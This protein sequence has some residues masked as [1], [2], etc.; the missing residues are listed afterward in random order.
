MTMP[1]DWYEIAFGQIYPAVYAH[2]DEA[3][4]VRV[5]Q[6][7]APLVV[8]ASP[9]LDVACGSGRYMTAFAQAG[10]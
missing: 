8:G 6:R 10:L 1:D 3:E 9:V 7:L 2:R 5:A 4:A